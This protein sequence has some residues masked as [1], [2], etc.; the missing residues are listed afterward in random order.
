VRPAGS[1]LPGYLSRLTGAGGVTVPRLRPPRPLFAPAGV[2]TDVE[3]QAPN[4]RLPGH[5]GADNPGPQTGRYDAV[6][7]HSAPPASPVGRVEN[8]SGPTR[9]GA[10]A[11]GAGTVDPSAGATASP[12]QHA[13]PAIPSAAAP[14]SPPAVSPARP[15]ENPSGPPRSGAG[16]LGAEAVDP[17]AGATASPAQHGAPPVLSDPVP[18]PPVADSPRGSA[19]NPGGPWRSG[20]H[21]FAA[22]GNLDMPTDPTPQL[23]PT[24][25]QASDSQMSSDR[26][27]R[28]ESVSAS[29]AQVSIGTI[30]VTVVPPAPTP[31]PNQNPLVGPNAA[32]SPGLASAEAARRAARRWFGAGQS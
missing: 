8:P 29:T 28:P 15:A 17:S 20:A 30:E 9:S 6:A 31:T 27:H 32:G 24:K 21:D 23:L 14:A 22:A 10:Q 12:A 2:A 5:A 11:P 19:R 18:A 26:R 4:T 3:T 16:P 1:A 25:R 7:P 13:A